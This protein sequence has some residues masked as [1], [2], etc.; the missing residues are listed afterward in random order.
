MMQILRKIDAS[1]GLVLDDGAKIMFLIFSGVALILCLAYQFLAVT[2]PYSLDYGEAPL[3]DQAMRL[4][5]GQN[6]YR[7]DIST[8]PY[9]ISNYPPLYVA[10]VAASVKLVG[11]SLS[12]FVGRIISILSTWVS[13]ILLML[14]VYAPTRDRFAA[15]SAG[16]IFLAFPFVVYWSPLLRIDMLALTLSLAGLCLVVWQPTSPRQLVGVALLLVAAIYTRQSY[17]LAAPLA[18]FVWLLARDWRRALKLALL[19]GGLGLVLF[20]LLNS[21]TRGGFFFNI[22][23]AN[24]NEFK[25]DLL[26]YNWDRFREAALIPLC[27]GVASLFLIPRWN[28]LWTLATPYLIGAALSAATIGKIG[29]NVNYLLELCAALSLSAGVIVASSRVHLSAYSL[30]AALLILL[31]FAVGKMVNV[32]LQD[33]TW[34]LRERRAATSKLSQ[35]ESL[36]A[37]TPGPILADEYMGMLTLQGRPLVIQPF[38]VTQLAWSGKWDQTPLLNSI[39][40]TEFAAI[41][42]YDRPWVNERWTQ[43]ML[44]AIN[45]SYMLVDVVAENKIYRAFQREASTSLS[46]CPGAV[47]RL[48]SDGALGVQWR[49]AGLDFLGQGNQGKVPVYAVA[50]GLLTRLTEW[51]DAVAIFHEDPLHPT[52]KVWSYYSGMAAA[53]GT[54]SYVAPDFPLGA[55]DIPVK[56]GQLLGYQG[57]WSGKPFWPRWLHVHFTVIRAEDQAEFPS[58][59]T[60][61]E[62]LEDPT[63]YLN[64]ELKSETDTQNSQPLECGQP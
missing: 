20:I 25:L 10:L 26:E 62:I 12:F 51:T 48:P 30:R 31:A 41:I 28:P 44:S 60:L 32:T 37:E 36:V 50:D 4:A 15:L 38:E 5:S 63:P 21:F 64:V 7:A 42:L 2:Y 17:G 47:W 34:E 40:K 18:A 33:Y 46:T 52:K 61:E 8:P 35:L 22:V 55:T 45:H 43:E 23:T 56:A 29:S 16:V 14:I 9:T 39:N 19:V 1:L 54:D 49:E 3:V 24:V 59:L 11:P 58:E 53:N 6:I 13:S 27:I 57:T